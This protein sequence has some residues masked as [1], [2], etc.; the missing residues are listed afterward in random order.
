M[1]TPKQIVVHHSATKD[2][3]TVSWNAIRKFHVRRCS[4]WSELLS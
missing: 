3:G 1:F 2:S 4:T